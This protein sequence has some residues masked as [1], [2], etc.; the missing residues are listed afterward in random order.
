MVSVSNRSFLCSPVS[1]NSKEHI[2]IKGS[3]SNLVYASLVFKEGMQTMAMLFLFLVYCC[4]SL[5]NPLSP[6]SVAVLCRRNEELL[7]WGAVPLQKGTQRGFWIGVFW[8]NSDLVL[9]CGRLAETE[10]E[11]WGCWGWGSPDAAMVVCG[12][13]RRDVLCCCPL[14]RGNVEK[15]GLSRLMTVRN[16]SDWI[17][18]LNYLK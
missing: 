11:M 17:K 3:T 1:L 6:P 4:F 8:K 7:G 16:P 15:K 9:W 12:T 2:L 18:R 5:Q 14:F 10:M 13:A